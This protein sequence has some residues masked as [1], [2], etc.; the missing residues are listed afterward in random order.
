ME[1]VLWW[2]IGLLVTVVSA[3]LGVVFFLAQR[4]QERVERRLRGYHHHGNMLQ[5]ILM[6]A[7][8][9]Y[10]EVFGREPPPT[11]EDEDK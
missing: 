9:T 5:Y 3:T 7:T 10:Q 8:A 4:W 6:L 11:P 1:S 2:I